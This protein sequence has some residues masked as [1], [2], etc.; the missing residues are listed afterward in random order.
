MVLIPDFF[1]S[2]HYNNSLAS[3]NDGLD[4]TSH[5]LDI[6]K[7]VSGIEFYRNKENDIIRPDPQTNS[8]TVTI[9]IYD[10]KG[11]IGRENGV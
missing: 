4:G 1:G 3:W 8:Q 11:I 2:A 9:R 5:P 10:W 7:I 6:G